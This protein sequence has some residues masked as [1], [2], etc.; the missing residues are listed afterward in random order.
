MTPPAV[1]V[2]SDAA[3]CHYEFSER[4]SSVAAN[5]FTSC[6]ERNEIFFVRKRKRSVDVGEFRFLCPGL[7]VLMDMP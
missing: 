6:C 2:F 1:E 3:A 4:R 5:R 7:V